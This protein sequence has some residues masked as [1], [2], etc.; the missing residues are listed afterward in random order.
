MPDLNKSDLHKH[1]IKVK[2]DA[3]GFQHEGMVATK[4]LQ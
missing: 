1:F 3:Y 2:L 4:I